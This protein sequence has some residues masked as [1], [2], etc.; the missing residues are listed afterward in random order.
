MMDNTVDTFSVWGRCWSFV[1]KNAVMFIALAAALVTVIF[2]LVDK[3][4]AGYFD[5]K[6]LTCLFCVFDYSYRRNAV[7]EAGVVLLGMGRNAPGGFL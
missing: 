3:E 6:T 5:Y 1:K 2:V 4:Y 7:A